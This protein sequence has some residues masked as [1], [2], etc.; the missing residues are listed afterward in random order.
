MTTTPV[1]DLLSDADTPAGLLILDRRKTLACFADGGTPMSVF[2]PQRPAVAAQLAGF[3]RG[4]RLSREESMTRA[5]RPT[6][7]LERRYEAYRNGVQ[8]L[9]EAYWEYVPADLRDLAPGRPATPPVV[10]P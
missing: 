6:E 8:Y 3:L 10:A 2:G 4:I 1:T 7:W 5:L 9:R